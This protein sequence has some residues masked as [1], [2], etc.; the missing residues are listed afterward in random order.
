MPRVRRRPSSRPAI[1]QAPARFQAEWIP[2]GRPESAP[3]LKVLLQ[4]V[5]ACAGKDDHD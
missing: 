3:A 2:V 4:K 1:C 5:P